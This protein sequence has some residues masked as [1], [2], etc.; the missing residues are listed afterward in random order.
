METGANR[1]LL[2]AERYLS[3]RAARGAILALLV[4]FFLV[5]IACVFHFIPHDHIFNLAFE[6]GPYIKTLREHGVYAY[7]VDQHWCPKVSR[8]PFLTL[9]YTLLSFFTTDQRAIGFI[10]LAIVAA[11]FV[12]AFL[13]LL[14]M[15]RANSAHALKVWV[16]MAA[17]LFLSPVLAKHAAAI[18]YEES[19]LIQLL[20][21]W[22]FSFLMM[23]RKLADGTRP[24]NAH[25]FGMMI[26]GTIAYLTKNSMVLFSF[27]SIAAALVVVVRYRSKAAI[28]GILI[29]LCALGAW[30]YHSI[31]SSGRF[32]IMT[33][34]DGLGQ[35]RGWDAEAA[36]VYPQVTLDQL[37]Y[38]PFKIYL[39]SGEMLSVP[40]LP[41]RPSFADEWA[42]SDFYKAKA[43]A[44]GREHPWDAAKYT[45]KKLY[46]FFVG[47]RKTPYSN[48]N[49]ARL[50]G[51][52][53]ERALTSTWLFAGRLL[54]ILFLVLVVQLWRQGA[55]NSRWLAGAS[56]AMTACYAAPYIV[57]YS[58]ER[59]ISVFL[60]LVAVCCAVMGAELWDRRSPAHAA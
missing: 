8:L 37:F 51:P 43:V 50:K 4:V 30:G 19:V 38:P 2:W 9:S 32:T 56:L 6:Y 46:V 22:S 29:C 44:W 33:S 59:H 35:Y 26:L 40:F 17:F 60:V 41:E 13:N 5:Q 16:V 52:V 1:A 28:A 47:I 11:C 49:D 3:D 18:M 48:T 58:S 25:V 14:S 27:L 39:E 24:G 31:A 20:L 10:K 36:I 42:Y 45:V 23:V 21:L 34:D 53:M 12:P 57:G 7:C 15:Q 54:Q 55:R